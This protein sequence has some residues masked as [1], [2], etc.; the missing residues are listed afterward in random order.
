MILIR[1]LF[2]L[3]HYHYMIHCIDYNCQSHCPHVY[4]FHRYSSSLPKVAAWIGEIGAVLNGQ[5]DIDH[6]QYRCMVIT[7]ARHWQT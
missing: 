7:K 5:A 3:I 6:I 1:F 4:F 2:I